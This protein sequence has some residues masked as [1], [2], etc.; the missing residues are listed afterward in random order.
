MTVVGID[1]SFR[2]FGIS[3]GHYHWV[4]E[5]QKGAA[6]A[7][8]A[9]DIYRR[10]R[11]IV[12]QFMNWI[13][14][15]HNGEHLVFYIEAPAFGAA[16]KT[17]SH[18]YE[19]GWLMC[20]LKRYEDVYSPK[21]R[22]VEVPPTTLKKFASGKGN[23]KKDEMKLAVYKRF[24]VEFD[25]DPGCDKLFAFLLHKFGTAVE[26]GEIMFTPSAKRGDK[27]KKKGAA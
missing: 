13:G 7:T 11:S 8:Q 12:G 23:T 22:V 1:P 25:D 19:L 15:Q 5:T 10:V 4:I 27:R 16:P 18:L 3:D 17:G 20:E 21:I 2:A 24:G 14:Q 26:S 9:D 6:E